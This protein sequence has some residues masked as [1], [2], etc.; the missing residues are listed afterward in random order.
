MT[1]K[2]IAVCAVVLVAALVFLGIR[3]IP[4][5]TSP[6]AT[7]ETEESDTT[8]YEYTTLEPLAPPQ[9]EILTPTTVKKPQ[10]EITT[11]IEENATR[12][13]QKKGWQDNDL[14]LD[15]PKI[16]TGNVSTFEYVT[17]YGRRTIIRINVLSYESYL[18]YVTQ[19]EEAGFAD[20]NNRA[21]IPP[22]A[23]AT[24]AMF[25]SSFDGERSFGAYWYGSESDAGF[26]CEIVIC[27]Y[28]QAL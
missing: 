14:T 15:L 5:N 8:K 12:L 2:I 17:D 24:V 13:N 20:N 23:P 6:G 11:R 18:G 9:T 26:S 22:T 7:P 10:Y 1:K 4:D 27:D 28:D 3:F 16:K 19:L 21:H 25:Y